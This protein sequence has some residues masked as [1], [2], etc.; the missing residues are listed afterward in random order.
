LENVVGA[1]F[2]ILSFMAVIVLVV[3][4]LGVIASMMGIFNFAHGEFVLL[5]AYTVFLFQTNGLPGWLG[6]LTAPVAVGLVGL[7]LERLVI[8]RFYASPIVAMLGTYA[9]GLSIREAVRWAIGGRYYSVAEPLPG[10]F[11]LGDLHLAKWRTAMI[12]I[13]VLV[14]AGSWLLLTRT[15]FGLRVRASLENPALARASGI[16][17]SRVYAA[18]FTFGAALAGL[19]GALVV[20]VF[21]LSA[22]LGIRFLIEGFLAVMLGGIGSFEGPVAGG[23]IIGLMSSGFPWIV[24]PILAE[25]LVFVVAIIAVKLMPAGLLGR[26]I[27]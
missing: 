7:V 27:A 13:T 18:T 5:G 20:P 1:S 4:G 14:M 17:T 9:L 19:A 3:L 6:M 21:S 11:A 23:A 10:S 24:S 2:D 16:A 12:L 25:V 15:E 8:R 26:R 22:D